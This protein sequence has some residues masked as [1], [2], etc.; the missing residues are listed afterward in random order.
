MSSSPEQSPSDL[1]T[2]WDDLSEQLLGPDAGTPI[3][4]VDDPLN[5]EGLDLDLLKE[6]EADETE[7][8]EAA[9]DLSFE[10]S[11]D[12]DQPSQE[13]EPISEATDLPADSPLETEEKDDYWDALQDLD[14][15][16]PEE[17]TPGKQKRSRSASSSRERTG[18]TSS[19]STASRKTEAEETPKRSYKTTEYLEDDEFGDGLLSEAALE[20][21][22]EAD[23]SSEEEESPATTP[24]ASRRGKGRRR[25]PSRKQASTDLEE[26]E[27]L[28]ADIESDEEE[29]G[30]G[31][32]SEVPSTP[33][34]QPKRKS[35][36][37]SRQRRRTRH[38]KTDDESA[39]TEEAATDQE[40]VSS[41]PSRGS[42]YRNVPTWEEAISYLVKGKKAHSGSGSRRSEKSSGGSRRRG[43]GR[44][45]N[46]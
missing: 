10:E 39:D 40:S 5:L 35:E 7:S 42:R 3:E 6:L 14:W 30:A 38:A 15:E 29:F 22:A 28:P 23:A 1:S 33:A 46:S 21:T 31:L 2:S 41:Q 34:R 18:R 17:K 11:S 12:S 44:R 27:E 19:R 37:A 4:P 32:L 20:S 45:S 9:E 16:D 36:P 24:S 25:G 26:L 13:P 8:A 43:R